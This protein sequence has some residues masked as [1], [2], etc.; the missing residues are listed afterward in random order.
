[1]KIFRC[2]RHKLKV[3]EYHAEMDVLSLVRIIGD[4]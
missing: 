2:K 1:M 3:T 4:N